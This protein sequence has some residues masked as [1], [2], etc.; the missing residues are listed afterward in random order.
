V[1]DGEKYTVATT[2]GSIQTA[3]ADPARQ[4]IQVAASEDRSPFTL[5]G[6]DVWARRRHRGSG[7]GH[8]LPGTLNVRLSPVT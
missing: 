7:P 6:G 3:D 2:L 4:G 1:L 8:H 5:F